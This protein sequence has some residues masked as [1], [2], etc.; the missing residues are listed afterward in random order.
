M[1]AFICRQLAEVFV[2]AAAALPTDLPADLEAARTR[3]VV[4]MIE[5]ANA[6]SPE[7]AAALRGAAWSYIATA[8][9]HFL[10]HMVPDPRRG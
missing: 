3:P 2:Q 1:E 6:A 8:S 10:V 7:T 9:R 5:F 4:A